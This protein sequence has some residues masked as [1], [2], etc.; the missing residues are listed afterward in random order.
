ML[1]HT[2]TC[3][4]PPRE[5][6]SSSDRGVGQRRIR[7]AD[8]P[9]WRSA[10]ITSSCLTL[11]SGKAPPSQM[12]TDPAI[13]LS[14]TSCCTRLITS[15]LSACSGRDGRCYYCTS[16]HISLHVPSPRPVEQTLLPLLPPHCPPLCIQ[17][18]GQ[19]CPAHDAHWPHHS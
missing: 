10:R 1:V 18:G 17:R 12:S 7:S 8:I 19:W 9:P 4:S 5:K 3:I 2:L 16:V 11:P 13:L 6:S 14:T 15:C